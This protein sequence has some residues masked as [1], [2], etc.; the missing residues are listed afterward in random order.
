MQLEGPGAE[1]IDT[2]EAPQ[3]PPQ[4]EIPQT[5]PSDEAPPE[6][7]E[8]PGE[9]EAPR[10]GS[11]LAELIQERTRRQGAEQS[12][13][14]S[15]ELIRAVMQAPGGAELLQRISSG[16]SATPTEDTEELEAIAAD[17]GLLKPDGT[18]DLDT[19]RRINSRTAR[20][21]QQAVQQAVRP[22]Q[23]QTLQMQAEGAIQHALVVAQRFGAD[24]SIVERGLRGVP[25]DQAMNPQVQQATI[26]MA[27]GLQ[28]IAAPGAGPQVPQGAGT[29]PLVT[30][31]PRGRGQGAARLDPLWRGRLKS[32]GLSDQ[33]IDGSLRNVDLRRPQKLE[34]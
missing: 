8:E 5:P 13:Q 12:V 17:L 9:P 2:P 21:V 14:Q 18:M 19:A 20:S 15:Q 30:E 11:M 22:L 6:E 34:P 4:E 32:A 26:L 29:A 10:R 28:G 1:P 33:E 27:L 23:Q 31:A 7:Q 16:Q 25:A 3:A 24:P